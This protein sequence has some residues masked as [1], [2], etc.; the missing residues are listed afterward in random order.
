MLAELGCARNHPRARARG[1]LS[2][3]AQANAPRGVPNLLRLG[4]L[5]PEL[6]EFQLEISGKVCPP[7]IA[8]RDGDFV[9]FLKDCCDAAPVVVLVVVGA[10]NRLFDDGVG[11]LLCGIAA[12]IVGSSLA[13]EAHGR[14]VLVW[15]GKQ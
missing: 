2:L 5:D 7:E 1:T 14:M 11:R 15:F 10:I 12:P 13:V 4:N 3:V 8:R 9:A 6:P